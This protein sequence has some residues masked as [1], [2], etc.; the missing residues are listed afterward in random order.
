MKLTLIKITMKKS[1]SD[2]ITQYLI[3]E[4][5]LQNWCRKM[6]NSK[7]EG[8]SVNSQSIKSVLLKKQLR[9]GK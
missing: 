9:N 3:N 5:K 8:K 1:H 2:S 4:I 7:F 6:N